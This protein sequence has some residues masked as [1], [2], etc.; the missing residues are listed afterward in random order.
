VPIPGYV[1]NHPSSNL[2][3]SRKID[4]VLRYV[5]IPAFLPLARG[6][7]AAGFGGRGLAG[8]FPHMGRHV[9]SLTFRHRHTSYTAVP[10]DPGGKESQRRQ[11]WDLAVRLIRLCPKIHSVRWETGLGVGESLWRV[12]PLTSLISPSDHTDRRSSRI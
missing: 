1:A 6:P 2:V 8:R 3:M 9:R 12:S 10:G 7:S 11:A 5:P 4:G